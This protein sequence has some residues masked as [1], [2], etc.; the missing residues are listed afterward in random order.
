MAVTVAVWA[1]FALGIRG[2]GTSS[3]TT[4]D[5]ALIRFVTPLLLLSPWIP[6]TLRRLRGERPT[7]LAGM[8]A[9]AGLP[10]FL[11]AAA[12]GRL[13]SAAL[14]GLVIPGT[15]PIFVALLAY[16]IRGSKIS[17]P[18]VAALTGILAGVA[19]AGGRPAGTGTLVLILAGAFWA[20]YT[21]S[22]RVTVLDPVGTVIALCLP[23]ALVSALSIMTGAA[24]SNLIH[25]TAAAGD[26]LLY[27][28]TQGAGVGVLAA[29]C[30]PIAIRRLG[31]RTAASLGAL[32]PVVT[33][34][35]ALPLFGEPF[36]GI[37][38][39]VL[40]I[41]GVVAFNL[42]PARSEG[43]AAHAAD[44]SPH[45]DRPALAADGRLRT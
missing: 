8:C 17:R 23:S 11:V 29:L 32:S 36:T 9:G 40:V 7:V 43:T 20:V 10:F 38:G 26:V 28:V 27:L 19:L 6:G 14:V 13:T 39:F 31:S 3:L 4:M 45:H 15:V 12:G 1:A 35:A 34:L 30:Y 42:M 37:P 16:R 18:Q 2:I 25:A 5:A 22:L 24:D 41:A 44:Q 33:A 21:M